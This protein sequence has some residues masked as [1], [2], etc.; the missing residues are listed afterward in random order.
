MLKA[1]APKDP[2]VFSYLALRKAVGTVALAL[3]FAVAIPWGLRYHAIQTSISAY[4][5]TGMRNLFVGSLCAIAMFMLCTRGYDR[6]DEVAGIFSA[7]CGIG[8]AFCPTSPECC[9][10]NRQ[11]V[12]GTIHYIFAALLFQDER[13]GPRRDAKKEAAQRRLHRLRNRDPS[14]PGL[15]PEPDVSDP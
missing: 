5:Y 10:T 15:A 7:V 8:V 13:C 4:Y 11:L 6:K 9:A 14:F 1:P 12:I 3:P 2:V